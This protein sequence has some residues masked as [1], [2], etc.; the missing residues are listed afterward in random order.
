M[1]AFLQV[2]SRSGKVAP[3]WE[4]TEAECGSQ[5]MDRVKRLI[6]DTL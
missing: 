4:M 2:A 6:V 5:E 1:S 3:L